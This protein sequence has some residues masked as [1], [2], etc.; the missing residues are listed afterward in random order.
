MDDVVDV[1]V[2]AIRSNHEFGSACVYVMAA[3]RKRMEIALNGGIDIKIGQFIDF[4][5]FTP[6]MAKQL[7][8]SMERAVQW[9]EA[10][11]FVPFMVSPRAPDTEVVSDRLGLSSLDAARIQSTV[12]ARA[13][14]GNDVGPEEG[15]QGGGSA[16]AAIPSVAATDFDFVVPA[17]GEGEYKLYRD[18]VDFQRKVVYVDRKRAGGSTADTPDDDGAAKAADA[19]RPLWFVYTVEAPRRDTGMPVCALGRLRPRHE[20]L[21]R[22]ECHEERGI[23]LGYSPVVVSEEAPA[24]KNQRS[25]DN[26][27]GVMDDV[28]V[29]KQILPGTGT[30]GYP[31]GYNDLVMDIH[32]NYQNILAASG[33]DPSKASSTMGKVGLRVFREHKLLGRRHNTAV[34][35]AHSVADM[36]QKALKYVE[37][38]AVEYGL[39]VNELAGTAASARFKVSYDEQNA[40]LREK[41]RRLREILTDFLRAVFDA[42]N[43]GNL[44]RVVG[45]AYQGYGARLAELTAIRSTLETKI[46][47]ARADVTALKAAP[48]DPREQDPGTSEDPV[49]ASNDPEEEDPLDFHEPPVP[50]T[51]DDMTDWLASVTQSYASITM[52]QDMLDAITSAAHPLSITWR[53]PLL[54]NMAMLGQLGTLV[55]MS[56][57]QRVAISRDYLGMTHS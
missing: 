45:E 42:K 8:R 25:L 32:A 46:A 27:I 39:Q 28:S 49:A 21:K 6:G 57:A 55:G 2:G 22:L 11:G 13:V 35:T 36:D 33:I 3:S 24:G 40:S 44:T 5:G 47:A 17:V 14:V 19:N 30:Q 1:D 34:V 31:P 26:H 29:T 53:H 54:T 48:P 41:A 4:P 51:V 9:I 20:R 43:V 38:V 18:P 23:E 52:A 50:A 15:E 56:P 16:A 12:G 10:A 37:A 7:C